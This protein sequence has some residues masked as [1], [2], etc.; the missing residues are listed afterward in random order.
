MLDRRLDLEPLYD[1]NLA[2]DPTDELF[3]L[4]ISLGL[5]WDLPNVT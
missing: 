5:R 2:A 4:P 1:L 3:S